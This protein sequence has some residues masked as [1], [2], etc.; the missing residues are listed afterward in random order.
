VLPAASLNPNRLIEAVVLFASRLAGIPKP[1]SP[2]VQ[3][4]FDRAQSAQK[5]PKSRFRK[6]HLSRFQALGFSVLV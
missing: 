6:K 2:A 3:P 4:D 1:R 5:C